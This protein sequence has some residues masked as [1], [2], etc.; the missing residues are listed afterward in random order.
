[1]V[2]TKTRTVHD[3]NNNN[4]RSSKL[5]LRAW[6]I[7]VV[8]M[9]S[10]VSLLSKYEVIVPFRC[11]SSAQV[12]RITFRALKIIISL[13]TMVISIIINNFTTMGASNNLP[14]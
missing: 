10:V 11:T 3:G 9:H 6:G 1:M 2:L 5:R 12:K 7:P 13:T 4:N 8:V 14:L